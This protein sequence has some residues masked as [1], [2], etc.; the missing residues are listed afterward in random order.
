MVV[1][2][3]VG[4]IVTGIIANLGYD[5]IFGNEEIVSGKVQ[6]AYEKA[7][8]RFYKKYK[9]E[10]GSELNS[11]LS[12]QKNIDIAIRSMFYSE[13]SLKASDI[14]GV[15][16][17]GYKDGTAEAIAD[18]IYFLKDEMYS[19][20]FLNKILTDK[21]HMKEIKKNQEDIKKG[22][23]GLKGFISHTF[24]KSID[25]LKDKLSSDIPLNIH[26]L[27]S[28]NIDYKPPTLVLDGI[29]RVEVVDHLV[30]SIEQHS[31][32]HLYGGVGT[33]KT[34]LLTLISD[35]YNGKVIWISMT[36]MSNEQAVAT[37]Q[38]S[39]AAS[40]NT[41]M[42]SNGDWY[43]EALSKFN[44]GD[45][46]LVDDLPISAFQNSL[47]DVI[48]KF[49]QMCRRKGVKLFTSASQD[50]NVKVKHQLGRNTIVSRNIPD[51]KE[52]EIKELLINKG[53]ST[54]MA[55]DL[56]TFL[57]AITHNNP[58]LLYMIAEY[59]AYHDWDMSKEVFETITKGDYANDLIHEIQKLLV[60]SIDDENAKEMLYRLS[61]VNE[62]FDTTV[63]TIIS[64]V[65]PNISHPYERLHKLMGKWVSMEEEQY[66]LSPLV[67]K[68]GEK[69]LQDEVKKAVHS[70]LGSHISSKGTLTP[71]EGMKLITHLL[72]AEEYNN[73][74]F[75]YL[76]LL[77]SLEEEN[78]SEDY[79]GITSLW[80]ETPLPEDITFD[81]K[82]IIRTKQLILL[83]KFNKDNTYIKEEVNE[84]ISNHH[85]ESNISL[86]LSYASILLSIHFMNTDTLSSLRYM[87]EALNKFDY[88]ILDKVEVE[89]DI[90]ELIWMLSHRLD[91]IEMVDEWMEMVKSLSPNQL[92]TASK[93]ELYP[94]GCLAIPTN[95]WMREH[96][97]DKSEQDWSLIYEYLNRLEGFSENVELHLM[98]SCVVRSKI[99][100][101]AEYMNKLE[102]AKNLGDNYLSNVVDDKS[103]FLINSILAKQFFIVKDYD[104][105]LP[106]YYKALSVTVNEYYLE[107][108]DA[109]LELAVCEDNINGPA[110]ATPMVKKAIEIFEDYEFVDEGKQAGLYGD[111]AI[112]LWKEGKLYESFEALENTL[113]KLNEN[114]FQDS[115]WK[116]TFSILGHVLGYYSSIIRTGNPPKEGK[117]SWEPY[118][119]AF[120]SRSEELTN[121][122]QESVTFHVH[123]LFFL[124]AD[125]M[126]KYVKAK[127]WLYSGLKII[128]A[129]NI[130]NAIS[131]YH[132]IN[133][134]SYL[135]SDD[136]VEEAIK[137][138]IR[139]QELLRASMVFYEKGWTQDTKERIDKETAFQ[140]ETNVKKNAF[141]NANHISL[142]KV[143]LYMS[144]VNLESSQDANT[145]Q[146]RVLD[147]ADKE[148]NDHSK[149]W[150]L[151]KKVF[152]E[153]V[154]PATKDGA[155]IELANNVTEDYKTTIQC[156]AYL[157]MSNHSTPEKAL[158]L[159]CKVL[160][161]LEQAFN[162]DEFGTDMILIPY[163]K[164]FWID[165]YIKQRINFSSTDEID[166]KLKSLI[167]DNEQRVVKDILL[168]MKNGL[169]VKLEQDVVDYL[170][171]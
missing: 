1:G 40:T 122:F 136:K 153:A 81:L 158:E 65:T 39:L 29:H 94:V 45:V 48:V 28:A 96:K 8:K 55:G 76:N 116:N 86:T 118:I 103:V 126:K 159:Q 105:A 12:R 165:R 72:N 166:E 23:K 80:R 31:W 74:A 33:G 151:V 54:K 104:K 26:K 97:K 111:L 142:P 57:A 155:I 169:G 82:L 115:S 46:I 25:V 128:D 164:K 17:D 152:E 15:S 16:F 3:A 144:T 49:I 127:E 171:S 145:I 92:S 41:N 36:C 64:D 134:I 79:W 157:A 125:G 35:R 71:L 85:H 60:E 51:F 2:S 156:L 101:L 109:Y 162:K 114:K 99:I 83:D 129:Y 59:L 75:A 138:S 139:G 42:N 38:T 130:E 137:T 93:G 160:Q 163:F 91:N 78:L 113:K 58:S 21:A 5:A 135:I 120:M 34:Q 73:L 131:T 149:F 44:E 87:K 22:L 98:T 150:D 18:F 170:E 20:F 95:I 117:D 89:G 62:Q 69:N 6:E 61:V 9:D 47:N 53:A 123:T 161:V 167:D 90:E 30:N 37:F 154:V 119:G 24:S 132:L 168:L 106:Y 141:Y 88:D 43:N 77:T 14:I 112:S 100:V 13:D 147:Y 10:F 27:S 84:Y 7:E 102:T 108:V 32:C 146:K 11:F 107:R 50:L 68:I 19:D 148:Y 52:S 124:L 66:K 67:N 133:S 143:M 63:L 140:A 4:G 70:R 121:F 110:N 56:S